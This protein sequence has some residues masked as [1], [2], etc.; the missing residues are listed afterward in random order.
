[1]LSTFSLSVIQKFLFPNHDGSKVKEKVSTCAFSR[2]RMHTHTQTHTLSL[3]HAHKHTHTRTHKLEQ[4][5]SIHTYTCSVL[6]TLSALSSFLSTL[7][8][9][10]S[11]LSSSSFLLHQNILTLSLF[12]LFKVG[13][14]G[15]CSTPCVSVKCWCISTSSTNSSD[16]NGH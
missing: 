7:S 15:S 11:P 6:K 5:T 1:V 16:S 10:L 9:L 14:V 8:S 2:T 13:F 12:K 3:F 4:E